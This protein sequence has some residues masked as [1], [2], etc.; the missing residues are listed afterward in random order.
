MLSRILFPDR[1]PYRILYIVTD[2]ISDYLFVTEKS[3][4]VNL[5]REGRDDNSAFLSAM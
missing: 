4:I 3:G 5:K 2:S 1:H